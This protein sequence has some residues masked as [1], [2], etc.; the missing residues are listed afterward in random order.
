VRS[1]RD[2]LT[3]L[4]AEVLGIEAPR[5]DDDF[6]RLGGD[7]L[8]AM[9]LAGR[10]QAVL[11]STVDISSIFHART[12]RR[13]ATLCVLASPGSPGDEHPQPTTKGTR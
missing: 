10:I 4:L 11:K 12:V 13:I 7:S 1:V 2:T 9:R 8:L 5:L 3:G 6:F